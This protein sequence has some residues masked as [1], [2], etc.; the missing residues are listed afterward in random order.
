VVWSVR[1]TAHSQYLK[2]GGGERHIGNLKGVGQ[3][4]N[5]LAG[6]DKGRLSP[7]TVSPDVSRRPQSVPA[8]PI[9]PLCQSVLVAMVNVS[10]LEVSVRPL[11]GRPNE[12]CQSVRE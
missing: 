11:L 10:V 1:P 12:D 9:D 3:P 4:T 8:R 2:R 6:P 7:P 5:R